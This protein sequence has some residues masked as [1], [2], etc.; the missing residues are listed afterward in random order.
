MRDAL[1]SRPFEGRFT[2]YL[3]NSIVWAMVAGPVLFHVTGRYAV[4]TGLVYGREW[5]G[6]VQ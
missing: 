2:G 1:F 3:T 6:P 5:E 4:Q